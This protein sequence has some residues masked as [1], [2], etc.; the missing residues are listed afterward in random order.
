MATPA[1]NNN[2]FA[3]IIAAFSIVN[4]RINPPTASIA[5]PIADTAIANPTTIFLMVGLILLNAVIAAVAMS[6]N[7]RNAAETNSPT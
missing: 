6:T 4:V 5:G 7:G 2:G 3:T 1:A